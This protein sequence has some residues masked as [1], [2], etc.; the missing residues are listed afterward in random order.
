VLHLTISLDL[1]L[2]LDQLFGA[3]IHPAQHLQTDC[4]NNDEEHDN[5]EKSRQ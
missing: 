3:L 1:A 4:T 5:G 2:Q